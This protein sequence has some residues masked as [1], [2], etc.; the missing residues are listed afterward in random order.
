[1]KLV[2]Q[3]VLLSCVCLY[4]CGGEEKDV[5][6]LMEGDDKISQL[7]PQ[8]LSA[9]GDKTIYFGHQSVGTNIM[10]GVEDLLKEH[11]KLPLKIIETS[12]AGAIEEGH[13]AH[14]KVGKNHDPDSKFNEFEEFMN[15]GIGKKVDVAFLKL[16]YVDIHT[17]TDL[18][19]TFEKYKQSYNR[20]KQKY[21]DTT[22]VHL[23]VPVT[24][25]YSGVKGVVK[26]AK[27]VAKELLGKPNKYDNS[28]KTKYNELIRKEY[29]GKEPLFDIAKV[30]STYPNGERRLVKNNESLVPQYTDDGNHLDAQGRKIVAEELLL[31][32]SKLDKEKQATDSTAAK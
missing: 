8:D 22:F 18:E 17:K 15:N 29:A 13:F 16:C 27:N 25:D 23:T 12:D 7:T 6:K 24:A 28:V 30:E 2:N 20:I 4:A 19:K 21:P 14:S 32:L 10:D 26:E 5:S 11:K 31:F 9:L 3:I 1:M